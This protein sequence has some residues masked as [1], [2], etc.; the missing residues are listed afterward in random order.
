M[1]F[2][3]ELR[4]AARGLVKA[5]GF[6]TAALVTLSLGMTLCTTAMVVFNAYLL[7][8]L[9]YPAAER[10][11]WIRYSGPGQDPLRNL[12]ALDWTALDD[13]VE[14]PIAW[15]LDMF[16]LLGG[17]YPE[18]APGA[19]VTPGYLQ[20]FGVRAVLGRDLGAADFEPGRPPVALI[21]HR[22]WQARFGGDPNVIGQRLSVYVSDRP[23]EPAQDS[24]SRRHR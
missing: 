7:T 24:P 17:S 13:V 22:L 3:R 8:G 11:Y 5:P 4:L 21:S 1:T 19:W 12:E 16:Y 18:S 15:D 9:P 23:N 14:H 20:G 2:A 6:T 10:L